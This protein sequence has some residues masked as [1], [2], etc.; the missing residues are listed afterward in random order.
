MAESGKNDEIKELIQIL[1]EF[2]QEQ[3]EFF[4]NLSKQAINVNDKYGVIIAREEGKKYADFLSKI[5]QFKNKM[6]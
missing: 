5:E 2:S 4:N 1:E 3:K 6:K